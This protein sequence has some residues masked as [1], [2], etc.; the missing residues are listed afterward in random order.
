MNHK[1]SARD[2]EITIEPLPSQVDESKKQSIKQTLTEDISAAIELYDSHLK[3]GCIKL[4]E[5]NKA[6]LTA[7]RKQARK[8]KL[9]RL[10][11]ITSLS[12]L[13]ILVSHFAT[14]VNVFTVV[15][16]I[17]SYFIGCLLHHKF[18]PEIELP[19]ERAELFTL[20]NKLRQEALAVENKQSGCLHRLLVAA[21]LDDDIKNSGLVNE[22]GEITAYQLD[23][24]GL[25]QY[26]DAMNLLMDHRTKLDAI[27]QG[28]AS[29]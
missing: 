25:Y 22:E 2:T 23:G 21:G 29:S 8:Q 16:L 9:Y 4:L 20:N 24:N 19:K 1:E 18:S 10:G 15:G 14:G 11:W 7:E 6:T 3:P 12:L 5:L 26:L 27:L 13:I 28:S 17:F